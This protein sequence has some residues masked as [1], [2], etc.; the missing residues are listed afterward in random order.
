M[1]D[2]NTEEKVENEEPAAPA[3]G[4]P[5]NTE[6]GTPAEEKNDEPAEEEEAESEETDEPAE[7]EPEKKEPEALADG[8]VETPREKALRLELAD[9]RRELSGKR[10]REFLGG[11]K[12]AEGAAPAANATVLSKYKKEDIDTLKEVLPV[13]AD[14]LGYA[15][16]GDIQQSDYDKQASSQVDAFIEKHPEYKPE[17]DK[18]N[19]LWQRLV[20]E[21]NNT[22]QKPKNPLAY[23]KLLERVHSD[24]FGATV[25][26][27]SL[28]D[29]AQRE[30]IKVASHAGASTSGSRREGM[31]RTPNQ[32]G[33]R[34]D[35]LKGFSDEEIAA[36]E[37][38][39][40]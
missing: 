20:N 32:N 27:P 19:V 33:M 3:E 25:S 8:T 4:A 36:L 30:K 12:K 34:F 1:A 5:E 7:G 28:K 22:Y 21:F 24:I 14:E 26:T 18:G 31:V 16:K 23:G 35:A 6:E 15:R 11:E 37:E 38:K 10:T 40:G 17:N 2:N 29:N 9:T 39:T 13:I